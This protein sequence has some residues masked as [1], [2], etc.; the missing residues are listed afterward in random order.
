MGHQNHAARPSSPPAAA[1]TPVT[2]TGGKYDLTNVIL[3]AP[4]AAGSGVIKSAI[5][6]DGT[7]LAASADAA[8]ATFYLP[9]LGAGETVQVTLSDRAVA[10][11]DQV[12]HWEEKP[13]ESMDLFFADR[14]VLRY[15]KVAHDNST[16][17]KHEMT[18]KVFHHVFDPKTGKVIRLFHPRRHSW[19]RHFRWDGPRLVGRTPI[20]RATVAVLAMNHPDRIALRELL[21]DEG[22][23]PP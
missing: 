11:S 1:Q 16:K 10:G 14:P 21:I 2:V 13:C 22:V 5:L 19:D 4:I 9:K 8:A 20:G 6:A 12:F 17:A 3:R 15:M 18:F 7:R 23:F